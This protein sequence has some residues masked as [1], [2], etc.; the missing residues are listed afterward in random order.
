MNNTD[1]G[2]IVCDHLQ[3]NCGSPDDCEHKLKRKIPGQYGCA[4]IRG[5]K[6]LV[7][8]LNNAYEVGFNDGKG[9][10]QNQEI[11]KTNEEC[12]KCQ[13]EVRKQ[14]DFDVTRLSKYLDQLLDAVDEDGTIKGLCITPRCVVVNLMQCI[15]EGDFKFIGEENTAGVQQDGEQDDLH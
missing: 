2:G 4:K 13:A 1:A 11:E 9:A 6:G 15:E 14:S 5:R 3:I 7:A 10:G 8:A 12:P